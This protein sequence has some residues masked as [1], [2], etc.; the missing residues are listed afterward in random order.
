MAR[1]KE[2]SVIDFTRGS[3]LWLYQVRMLFEGIVSTLIVALIIGFVIGGSYAY[4][5]V[6]EPD[7]AAAKIN[8]IATVRL[9]LKMDKTG[10]EVNQDG[11]FFEVPLQ[12]AIDAT[13]RSTVRLQKTLKNSVILGGIFG[14]CASLLLSLYWANFGKK[15]MSDQRLRGADLV[16]GEELKR[17]LIDENDASRYEIAG[18]PIRKNSETLNIILAGAPGS[19]KSQQIKALLRQIRANGKRAVVYDPSGEFTENF[20]REGKDIIMNPLDSRSP[21]WNVWEEIKEEYH[22]ENMAN[23]LIPVPSSGD[24]FWANAGRMLLKDVYRTLAEEGRMTNK[25]LYD[26]IA[27]QDLS[28][29]HLMLAGKSGATFVDPKTEKTGI[30]LKMTIQNQLESFRYLHDEGE[31]FSIRDWVANE[32]DSWMFISTRENIREVLKP[33]LSLW[34]T[35]IIKAVMDL[36]AI[37]EE[38]FWLVLD[39]L[40]TLQRIDE[41]MLSLTNTRKY[42]LC[43]ILGVQDF[44]QLYELYGQNLSK[45]I[46][47]SCQTKLLLRV[48]DNVAAKAMSEMMGE[49]EI[50]EKELSR[51]M[52][53]ASARDG[54]SF[55]GRRNIRSIVMT[56]EILTLP[57]LTGYLIVAGDYPVARVSYDYVQ[58]D[59]VA[60]SF[61]DRLQKNKKK[62]DQD[63]D[64]SSNTSTDDPSALD[65]DNSIQEADSSHVSDENSALQ[66]APVNPIHQHHDELFK[67]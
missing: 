44:S 56:S 13:E 35:T 14:V 22:Y 36:P 15:A 9:A 4:F 5:K 23:G 7:L 26:S 54:V 49:A 34:I 59:K 61:I 40:P 27:I 63:K 66:E 41:L 16:T 12:R 55:Y 57:D 60:L 53:A 10:I 20:F 45:T 52:G 19:G 6:S 29:L 8:Y 50:D 28:E 46:I 48:T 30:N 47:S 67:L 33:V 3:E 2:G 21:R 43:H 18:V 31:P 65:Q 58:M 64:Q 38:R 17:I 32:D 51:T 42:G 37:H 39:E 25:E 11:K 62:D 24:P 1:D